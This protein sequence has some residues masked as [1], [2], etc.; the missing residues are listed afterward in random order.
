MV[1]FGAP[2]TSHVVPT[3]LCA[4]HVALVA[5]FPLV[6]AHGVDAEKWR[7]V[8]AVEAP[9]GEAFVGAIGALVGAWAGAVPI[10]L[11]GD[12]LS[13]SFFFS[14]FSRGY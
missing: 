2:A 14:S 11:G 1:L 3:L 4:A 9:I 8:L 7:Q 10:P 5:A 12:S 13:L 6:C